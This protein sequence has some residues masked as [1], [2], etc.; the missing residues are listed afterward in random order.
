M[1]AQ[2]SPT[3]AE[4]EAILDTPQVD[5]NINDSDF[6][7]CDTP[8]GVLGVYSGISNQQ[9]NPYFGEATLLANT[10]SAKWL[11]SLFRVPASRP[12]VTTKPM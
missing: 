4:R 1:I 7:F 5:G 9:S 2:W 11:A 10:T 12:R 6:D 3:A 8:E